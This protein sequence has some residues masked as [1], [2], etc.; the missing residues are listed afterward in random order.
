MVMSGQAGI[1]GVVWRLVDLFVKLLY[2][3][4]PLMECFHIW[5]DA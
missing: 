5:S 3:L 1:A 2:F 4:Y